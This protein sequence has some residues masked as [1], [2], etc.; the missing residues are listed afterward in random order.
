MV[1]TLKVGSFGKCLDLVKILRPHLTKVQFNSSIPQV[2][3]KEG[4]QMAGIKEGKMV[5]AYVGF[6]TMTTLFSGNTLYIDDLTID[7]S[8]HEQGLAAVLLD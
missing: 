1:S 3:T 5:L 4:S 8:Y 7:P 2:L 6:R